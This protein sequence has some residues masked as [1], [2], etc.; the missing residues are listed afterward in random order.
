VDNGGKVTAVDCFVRAYNAELISE[1]PNNTPA[2]GESE[3]FDLPPQGG[4]VAMVN[5]YLSDTSEV[6]SQGGVKALAVGPF[7]FRT[8]CKNGES[9]YV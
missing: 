8:E 1:E 6:S 7:V 5:V 3:R 4:Y 2:S 9:P